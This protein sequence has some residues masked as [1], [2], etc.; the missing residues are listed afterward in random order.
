[1]NPF[2]GEVCSPLRGRRVYVGASVV[3]PGL[4]SIFSRL[5]PDLRPGLYY[6]AASRLRCLDF[7]TQALE[8]R[9]H[10]W[11]LGGTSGTR[12]LPRIPSFRIGAR[13]VG[14]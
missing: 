13:N 3:P 7:H 12:A 6:A 10:F 8:Q 1:M 11:R 9:T 2:W 4:G 5:T 14:R